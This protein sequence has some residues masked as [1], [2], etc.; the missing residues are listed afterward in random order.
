MNTSRSTILCANVSLV[1]SLLLVSCSDNPF[2]T[3]DQK[4]GGSTGPAVPESWAFDIPDPIA[5]SKA[6]DREALN[7]Q[8]IIDGQEFPS[9]RED[10]AF[11]M[12]GT[13]P[14]EQVLQVEVVW[15]EQYEGRALEIAAWYGEVG[16]LAANETIT[17]DPANYAIEVFDADLDGLS[18]FNERDTGTDP[19]DPADPSMAEAESLGNVRLL[20]RWLGTYLYDEG[21]RAGYGDVTDESA[22]WEQLA[23]DGHVAFR[24]RQT[25]D[26]LN[27]QE[28]LEYVQAA[29]GTARLRSAQWSLEPYEGYQK[30]V[31]RVRDD[32]YLNTEL[33][34]GYAQATANLAEEAESTQW[35]LLPA[36]VESE[37]TS[38]EEPAGEPDEAPADASADAPVGTAA[39]E[40]AEPLDGEPMAG[41]D[42][43]GSVPCSA[44][45]RTL[46]VAVLAEVNRIRSSEQ[47][48]G[49]ELMPSTTPLRWNDE[50]AEATKAHSLDMAT[51]NFLDEVGS[52]GV[53][54]WEKAFALGYQ[55]GIVVA[56]SSRYPSVVAFVEG[57]LTTEPICGNL[58]NPDFDEIGVSCET[59]ASADLE[60]YWTVLYGVRAGL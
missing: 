7:V 25:G 27:L 21:D 26:F 29:G 44:P 42:G 48:C 28:D 3:T 59:N 50:L 11:V 43:S 15:V 56:L 41:A 1:V 52:D 37:P 45:S 46:R 39:G 16:P 33:Q 19:N 22:V 14:V 57:K 38:N 4:H 30:I 60:N 12:S 58:M 49:T 2:G 13:V 10:G 51:N 54:V 32:Q 35:T 9:S 20:N 23:V 5:Q 53:G 47:Q 24:N 31:N 8:F 55:N 34:L 18:N 36:D 40:P 6:I 17:L